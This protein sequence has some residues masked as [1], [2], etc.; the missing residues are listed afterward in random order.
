MNEDENK[1]IIFQHMI[2][3]R[4]IKPV[5]L[6][7]DID[8]GILK[9]ADFGSAK[10][11]QRGS[12]S[13][14]YQVTRFYRPP[15]LLLEAK[16]YYWMV[17]V[18]SAGCCVGEMM[19]GKVLFPGASGKMMLKLIVQAIGLPSQR[20][21]DYMKVSKMIDPESDV[22]V[23]GFKEILGNVKDE[24]ADFIG[25][26]L[27]YRP[28]ERLHGPKLLAHSFFD[29]I[30]TTKCTLSNGLLVSQVITAED[31]KIAL[32]ND[33]VSGR[34]YATM[35][36]RNEVKFSL[37]D[38]NRN[39]NVTPIAASKDSK[40][41]KES[42]DSKESKETFLIPVA[43]EARKNQLGVKLT[44]D[45]V[46][47]EQDE[48]MSSQTL[49]VDDHMD[50]MWTID[51]HEPNFEEMFSW[52]HR[53]MELSCDNFLR[54]TE[55][56]DLM[57]SKSF[58]VAILEPLSVCGLGF[59]KKLGI[60]KTI[61][62]SSCSL[63]DFILPNIGEPE[64]HSYVPSLSSQT[65]DQMSLFERYKNYRFSKETKQTMD[66]M[67][68]QETR[69]YRKHLGEDLP[70]WR[71]LLPSA[72]LFFTNSNPYL[73]FP[74]PVIQKTV[75]IGG[76]SVNMKKIKSEKL[77]SNWDRILDEREHNMLI[78]FGSMVKSS[79]MPFEWKENIVRVIKSEPNVTFIWKYE[80][81]ETQFA[82]GLDNVVFSNWV[83]QTALL[84][85]ERLTA[86]LTH[87]GLGST[88]ELA[89]CG[90]PAV[91]VPIFGDQ[92]RNANMLARHKGS[93]FVLK[94]DLGSFEILKKAVHSI[95]YD[96]EYKKNAKHL[97]EILSNQPHQPK[98]LVVKHTEFLAQ[99]GPFPKMDP[100]GRSLNFFARNFIDIYATIAFSY[101]TFGFLSLV[102]LR[103]VLL[104][105]GVS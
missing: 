94:N 42:K 79:Q 1:G 83:P 45:V 66:K 81:N 64:E 74:R 82:A 50:A 9:I 105:F 13:T 22:K 101:L 62:A 92:V 78:S 103:Q 25:E 100:F 15:E 71:E 12:Y 73:D 32:K 18:W 24:W 20:D 49:V 86:F 54:N 87:G 26:I 34:K 60:E 33:C 41:N 23:K 102:I 95:L 69:I 10:I 37:K 90:K 57:R 31:Y 40:E 61:L 17:D 76:I 46:I 56:F 2:V 85:D 4:D 28:R 14:S 96:K 97:A 39:A 65:G 7:I 63:Y 72:S 8:K 16:E 99:F 67:F 89:H 19:A 11:V 43:D 84:N 21:H 27:R 44:K 36:L 80:T 51:T 98:D 68:D 70:D 88:N 48:I 6:L 53:I 58:D 91:M 35:I 59:F 29:N 77:N 38:S 75:P 5:N 30:F 104:L 52:F 93:I 47:V 55:V 3:H